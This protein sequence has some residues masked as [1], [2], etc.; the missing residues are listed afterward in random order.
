MTGEQLMLALRP[1]KD[2][3]ASA[4]IE[5]VK[6]LNTKLSDYKRVQGVLVCSEEFPRTASQ[7]IKRDDLAKQLRSAFKREAVQPL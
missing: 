2:V 7:K 1:K 5:Q 3:D 6:K 4:L